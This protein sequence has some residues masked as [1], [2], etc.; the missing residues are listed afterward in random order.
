[1]EE[2]KNCAFQYALKDG[3]VLMDTALITIDEAWTL[4]VN[5]L[6]QFKEHLLRE[7]SSEMVIW[8][9]MNDRWDYHTMVKLLNSDNV[10]I[11]DGKMYQ[12]VEVEE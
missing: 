8:T 7:R 2:Q 5:Y 3:T 10:I 11:K 12:L 1:M 6:P 9:D 4:W